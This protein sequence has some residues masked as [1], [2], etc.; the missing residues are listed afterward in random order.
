[1]KKKIVRVSCPPPV[2]NV[3]P[4][5]AGPQG[6]PGAPG[7]PGT[8][9]T[10][11]AQGPQGPAGGISDFAFFCSTEEQ[12]VAAPA[13]VG[14]Q[15]GAVTFNE[16][17]IIVNGAI[18]FAPPSSILINESG[19][20]N[21]IYHVFPGAG[22]NAFGLF[23]DPDGAGP[24]PAELVPCSNY[25]TTAGAQPYDGKVTAFLTAGGILT[26]NNINNNDQVL[27]NLPSGPPPASPFVVSAS[28]KIEKL[29]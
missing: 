7:A 8:P 11:G 25:G 22:S 24:L 20:Y 23:F 4:G 15:G 29:A 5:P 12:T 19:F 2:V 6:A 10:P 1:M 9:G 27:M 26:L 17:P 3:S 28:V 14:G 18:G 16:A 21:I 13:V